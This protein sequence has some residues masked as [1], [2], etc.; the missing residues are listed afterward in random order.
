MPGKMACETRGLE[1]DF[2]FLYRLHRRIKFPF[3]A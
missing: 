1:V 3:C 2:L